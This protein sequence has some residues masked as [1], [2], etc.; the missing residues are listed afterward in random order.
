MDE[1][2]DFLDEHADVL[3]SETDGTAYGFEI[4]SIN[5]ED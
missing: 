5:S 2:R 3:K 1:L 4:V